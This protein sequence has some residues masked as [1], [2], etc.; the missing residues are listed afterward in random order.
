[1]TSF[2]TFAYA[3]SVNAAHGFE[4][5]FSRAFLRTKQKGAQCLNLNFGKKYEVLY[6]V[7]YEVRTR[8][9]T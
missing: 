4:T 3:L 8:T 7:L 6:E 2:D 9:I 5:T 1:M